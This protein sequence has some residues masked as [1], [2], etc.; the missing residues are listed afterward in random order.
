M[1]PPTLLAGPGTEAATN[2]VA[3]GIRCS[4]PS[5]LSP[6]HTCGSRERASIG[7]SESG[8]EGDGAVHGGEVEAVQ[9]GEQELQREQKSDGSRGSWALLEGFGEREGWEENGRTGL[10]LQPLRQPGEGATRQV[11]HHAPLRHHAHLLARLPLSIRSWKDWNRQREEA[12]LGLAKGQQ[13]WPLPSGEVSGLGGAGGESDDSNPDNPLVGVGHGLDRTWGVRHPPSLRFDPREPGF[14]RRRR[15]MPIGGIRSRRDRVGQ[16]SRPPAAAF[17]PAA[18][19]SIAPGRRQVHVV[20]APRHVAGMGRE[21]L[22]W[23]CEGPYSLFVDA[24]IPIRTRRLSL[25]L[26]SPPWMYTRTYE[27]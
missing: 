14:T 2:V 17:G 23:R 8:E 19:P 21:R 1:G 13:R 6:P 15:R 5:P 3:A 25:C 27:S 7:S 22:T 10:L 12:P 20:R 18:A 24:V 16:R 26:L 9:E 11:L 4:P